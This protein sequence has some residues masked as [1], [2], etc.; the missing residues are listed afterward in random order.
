MTDDQPTVIEDALERVVA[1]ARAHLAAVRDAAAAT[2]DAAVWRGYVALN[3]ASHAYD[4]LLLD[5]YGEVTP[6][7]TEPIDPADVD[8]QPRL[9]TGPDRPIGEFRADPHPGVVSVRQRRDYRVPSVAALL[10]AGRTAADDRVP[11]PATV[12][13][14]VLDRKSVV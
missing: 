9:V 14:A 4:Q 2:D 11:A 8:S 12:A 3:N 7:E 5:A 1:A 10:A 6:W 13:D